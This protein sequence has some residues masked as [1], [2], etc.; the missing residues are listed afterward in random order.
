MRRTRSARPR[1]PEPRSVSRGVVGRQH[2]AARGEGRALLQMQ[3]GDDQQHAASA[4]QSAPERSA[5]TPQP[6]R[7]R[8]CRP[9][10]ARAAQVAWRS[11]R[12][13]H[14]MASAISVRLGLR[15]DHPPPPRRR[16]LL[17]DLQHHRDGEGRDVVQRLC[18]MRPLMRASISPRRATSIRPVAASARAQ[19]SSRW[20]RL[21]AAQ[22]VVD[23]VGGEGDLAA[24]TSP[25]PGSGARSGRR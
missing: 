17:A 4:S 10:H 2:L 13:V 15:Q 16:P 9:P 5:A 19:R 24:A 22:H 14:D 20:S 11:R 21:V 12:G 6:G 18:T 3:V 8:Q 25:R 23:Q 7:R 1:P